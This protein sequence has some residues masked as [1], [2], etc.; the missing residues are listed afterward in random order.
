[1]TSDNETTVTLPSADEFSKEVLQLHKSEELGVIEATT[2]VCEKYGIEP[3][4]SKKL[5][6]EPLKVAI[7]A[8]A[9][10]LNLLKQ[11]VK[12]KRLF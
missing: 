12:T 3:E 9:A 10:N 8:E 4:L 7:H 1:M 2:T 11:K 6:A 5:I